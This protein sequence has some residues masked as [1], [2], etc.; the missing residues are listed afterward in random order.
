[1]PIAEHE[2]IVNRELQKLVAS[3]SEES[4]QMKAAFEAE[5]KKAERI[6][7]K[8]ETRLKERLTEVEQELAVN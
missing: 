7:R 4:Q 5:L 1:M 8:E 2:A 6:I 3:Q